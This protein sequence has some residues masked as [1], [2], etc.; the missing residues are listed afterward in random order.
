MLNLE[1]LWSNKEVC[2]HAN[3]DFARALSSSSS[4][5][6]YGYLMASHPLAAEDYALQDATPQD[7]RHH[8]PILNHDRIDDDEHVHLASL[9]EK[10]RLWWRNAVINA[11][12]IASW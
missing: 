2:R 6:E 1:A 10:K 3:D 11:L 9:A 7:S 8:Y 4:K 12:F 5:S